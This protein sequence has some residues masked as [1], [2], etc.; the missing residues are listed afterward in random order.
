MYLNIVL[1]PFCFLLTTNA[2]R[3]DGPP[4]QAVEVSLGVCMAL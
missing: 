2:S 4:P 1:F 3:E